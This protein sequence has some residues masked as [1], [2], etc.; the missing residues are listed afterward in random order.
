MPCPFSAAF[1]KSPDSGHL[2]DVWERRTGFSN[3]I[4]D[5]LPLRRALMSHSPFMKEHIPT[6]S[7]SDDA[8]DQSPNSDHV[9]TKVKTSL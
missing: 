4:L 6:N 9:R 3:R 2:V 7:H 5:L 1:L 8:W